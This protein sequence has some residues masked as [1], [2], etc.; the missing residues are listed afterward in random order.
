LANSAFPFLQAIDSPVLVMDLHARIIWL[1]EA[2]ETLFGFS[3]E[4]L[5][6][7]L[8][9]ENL[10]VPDCVNTA[11]RHYTSIPA[12]QCTLKMQ[13]KSGEHTLVRWNNQWI[14]D[15]SEE[16]SCVVMAASSHN[17]QPVETLSDQIPNFTRRRKAD[18]ALQESEIRFQTL[19]DSAAEFIFVIDPEGRIMLTN[20]Y[21]SDQSC[22]E[23][24]EL[25][26]RS[27]KDF[28]TEESKHICD[29]NFPG[30]RERGHNRAEIEFVCKDGRILQMECSATGIPDK[31]NEFTSFLIIQR[32]VTERKRSAEALADSE[33]RFRAIFNSTFQFIGLLDPEGTLLEAN[34]AALDFAGVTN[35]DVVGKPF[36]ETTWWSGSAREQKRLKEAIQKASQGHLV[37]YETTNSGADGKIFSVDFSLKPVKNEHGE[38]VLII[39]EGRD[40]T[41]RKQAE[42][43]VRRHQRESAHFMRLSLMG[44]MAAGMA[45]ELNQPLAAMTSYCGTA[46]SILS[47]L[48]SAPKDLVGLLDRIAEQAHRASEIINHIRR[49]VSKGSTNKG[50]ID[51][52]KL[53]IE[54]FDFLEW[55]LRN[56]KVNID[57][58][59][60]AQGR[61]ISAN[62]VQIEQVLLNLI[63]N[64]LEAIQNA[65][66]S[67]GRLILKTRLIAGNSVQITVTDNGPG[68]AVEMRKRLFEPFQTSKESGMGM[69]LSIGRSIIQA[70]KGKIWLNES[71]KDGSS[72][73]VELPVIDETRET[74]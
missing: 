27:I 29:C 34:Q 12:K 1:N 46:R 19:F 38:T 72:F 51:I 44:E 25:I 22:Y 21:V 11:R 2:G 56:N 15:P 8:L 73:C 13:T 33:R 39:P 47:E 35:D 62:S 58:D 57:L 7:S 9:W 43:E 5:K 4:E 65:G 67:N 53:I 60:D 54:M 66:I 74:S 52:D 28:F 41:E 18:S 31:N 49:F 17:H 63:R 26:G 14:S 20:R 61:K 3:N 71:C 30:L 68:I 45:H 40:I 32:D 55:E 10:I 6:G 69:G 64:S 59:M 37:R 48:P 50:F 42:E 36:W 24:D 16:T 70:H 23:Q